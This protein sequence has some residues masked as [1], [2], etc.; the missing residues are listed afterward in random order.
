M[1]VNFGDCYSYGEVV[2]FFVVSFW[3]CDNGVF[4]CDYGIVVGLVRKWLI[5]KEIIL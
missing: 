5:Y 3:W 4:M 1:I 2:N